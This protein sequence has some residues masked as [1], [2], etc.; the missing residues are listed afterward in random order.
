[1]RDRKKKV[2]ATFSGFLAAA[3]SADICCFYRL[4]SQDRKGGEEGRGRVRNYAK[5]V[6]R[7]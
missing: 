4:A 1:M 7:T 5:I 6:C 2:V 3:S